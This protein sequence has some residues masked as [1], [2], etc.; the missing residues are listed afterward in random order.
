MKGTKAPKFLKYEN[1]NSLQEEK[2]S[3]L[4]GGEKRIV[5]RRFCARSCLAVLDVQ[6]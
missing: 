4:M 6:N 5:E 2:K 1:N 3:D